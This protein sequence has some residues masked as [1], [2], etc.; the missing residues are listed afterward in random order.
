[1]AKRIV[2]FLETMC[3]EKL[4]LSSDIPMTALLSHGYIRVLVRTASCDLAS[5]MIQAAKMTSLHDEVVAMTQAIESVFLP[6]LSHQVYTSS[7]ENL[8]GSFYGDT[9]CGLLQQWIH[10]ATVIAAKV[11]TWIV[12]DGA[13]SQDMTDAVVSFLEQHLNMRLFNM[14]KGIQHTWRLVVE[15]DTLAQV[16]PSFAAVSGHVYMDADC[17][18]WRQILSTW[19]QRPGSNG[20]VHSKA[21]SDTALWVMT[22]TFGLLK[23]PSTTRQTHHMLS[24]CRLV[25]MVVE[26]DGGW[27]AQGH[28]SVVLAEGYFVFA[29]VWCIGGGLEDGDVKQ[30]FSDSLKEVLAGTKPHM[31]R[32][33]VPFPPGTSKAVFDFVFD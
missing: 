28:Q 30:A 2:R 24:V 31:R 18:T 1:M 8:V 29:A 20:K 21:I 11:E 22:V 10:D 7:V 19:C 33:A 9:R 32:S 5:H 27:P 15:T 25:D 12:L 17:L 13:A 4:N 3:I 14:A 6:R 26:A 23:Q 16:S